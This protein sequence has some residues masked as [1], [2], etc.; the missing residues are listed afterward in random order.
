ME[1]TVS[2]YTHATAALLAPDAENGSTSS[3]PPLAPSLHAESASSSTQEDIRP[4]TEPLGAAATKPQKRK[5]RD[6]LDSALD[7]GYWN[8]DVSV[9]RRPKRSRFQKLLDKE[10]D[11][12]PKEPTQAK[13]PAAK[14]NHR[15]QSKN[16]ST[17]TA[18]K[19]KSRSERSATSASTTG[20]QVKK[21]QAKCGQSSS[22]ESTPVSSQATLQSEQSSTTTLTT[23]TVDDTSTTTST[24]GK[25]ANPQTAIPSPADPPND[26]PDLRKGDAWPNPRCKVSYKRLGDF[27]KKGLADVLVREMEDTQ[28]WLN[29]HGKLER[30]ARIHLEER[31]EWV[32]DWYDWWV[33]EPRKT[34]NRTG[35]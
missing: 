10:G 23:G 20:I 15:S 14:R 33:D 21:S 19:A 7:A 31:G 2:M 4:M 8:T 3:S 28:K 32:D 27:P 30:E 29:E 18:S 22:N 35:Q 16:E 17:Q 24:T 34:R 1:N 5:R 12:E 25:I 6:S 26:D 13:K 9:K 11:V